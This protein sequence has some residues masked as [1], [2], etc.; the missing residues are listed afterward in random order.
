MI[1]FKIY[2]RLGDPG[3]GRFYVKYRRLGVWWTWKETHHVLKGGPYK[4]VRFF[5]NR[6]SALAAFRAENTE[7]P[8]QHKDTVVLAGKLNPRTGAI[9]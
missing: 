6:C 3:Q 9:E 4:T 2:E 5:P 1:P 7:P 8:K